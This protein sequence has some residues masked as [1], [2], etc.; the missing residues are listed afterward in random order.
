MRTFIAA[1]LIAIGSFA[2]MAPAAANTIDFGALN[3]GSIDGSLDFAD[4]SFS[5]ST[6]RLYIGA[7]GGSNAVCPL[8]GSH[9]VA[10]LTVTFASPVDNL[11]FLANG[12]N[13]ASSSVFVSGMSTSGAFSFTGGS[14]DG[15]LSTFATIDLSA[16]GG[17]TSIAVTNNDPAGL[18]Y[19]FFSF[20]ALSEGGSGSTVPEP[21][22]WALMLAG[23]GLV[24]SAMRRRGPAL[25]VAS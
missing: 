11:S 15:V 18:G 3:I 13:N 4:A 2:A 22:A 12:D 21:A 20:D 14:F 7:S 17:I 19:D 16:F 9:C 23:F 1:A 10:T 5:S 8:N 6:G 24:G 25:A